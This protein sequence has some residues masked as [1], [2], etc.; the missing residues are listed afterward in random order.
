MWSAT[1]A[2]RLPIGGQLRHS[3]VAHLDDGE[4]GHHEEGVDDDEEYDADDLD[5]GRAHRRHHPAGGAVGRRGYCG[6]RQACPFR[7]AQA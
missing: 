2:R 7:Y 3:G 1:R 5:R 6:D 4:L